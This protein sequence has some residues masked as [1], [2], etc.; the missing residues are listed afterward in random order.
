MREIIE[1]VSCG[2]FADAEPEAMERRLFR[3]MCATVVTAVLAS[4]PL[5]P[6]RVTAGLLLGGVLSLFNHH[7]LRTSIIAAFSS[8]GVGIR[9]RLK[10]S[11]YILR[12]FVVALIVA[13]AYKLSV[14]SLVATLLGLCSFVVAVM[15]EGFIQ[16]FFVIVHREDN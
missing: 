9:P 10:A 16:I 14:V 12:Y 4:A 13:V 7:W 11:R 6:W 8:T 3:I 1:N 15:A 2:A 5:A